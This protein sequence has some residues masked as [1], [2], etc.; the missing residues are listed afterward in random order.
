MDALQHSTAE[1]KPEQRGIDGDI[2]AQFRRLFSSCGVFDL[3]SRS[4]LRVKGDDRVRWLNGMITNNVRDL[5]VAHGV[6]GFLLNPQGRIQADLYAYNRGDTLIV[7]VDELLRKKVLSIFDRY[8]IMDD[9]EIEDLRDKLASIGVAGPGSRDT[10]KRASVEVPELQP[11]QF[12]DVQCSGRSATLVHGDNPLVESF[13]L[14]VAPEDFSPVWDRLIAAGAEAIGADALE[15]VRIA[16]G[17]PRYGQD[18]RERD[19]PQETEQQRALNFTKGCYV[20]QEIVERIR[21]RGSVHRKFTGFAIDGP[22]PSP[23]TKIQAE[24]KDVGEVTSSAYLPV[25]TGDRAIAL[26]YIRREFTNPAQ[27]LAAGEAKAR[28][29]EL[30]LRELVRNHPSNS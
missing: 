2:R 30:P 29:V 19:L 11:L 8:I 1:L 15:L 20:G 10:L 4:K 3:R 25:Q 22:L 7:D 13:E 17:V 16:S 14:W 12:I 9:V 21:S 28:I 18:I 5:A 23:G 24:G 27:D 6:Y 26:G